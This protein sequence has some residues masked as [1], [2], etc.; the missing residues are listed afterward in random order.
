M[1]MLDSKIPFYNAQY[2]LILIRN[3]YTFSG[4]PRLFLPVKYI[5]TELVYPI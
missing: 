3:I 4:L 2:Q 5:C 1:I